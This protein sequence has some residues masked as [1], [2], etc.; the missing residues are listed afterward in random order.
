MRGTLLC[1]LTDGE[2][3]G[4]TLALGADLSDRLGLRLVLAHAV[5]V[6]ENGR[7]DGS[8]SFLARASRQDAERRL[9]RL[10]DEQGVADRAER[11]V[12]LGEPA[13]SIGQ[14]A[15]EE[16]ADVIVVG[17]RARGWRRRL[18]SRLADQLRTETPVPVLIAPPR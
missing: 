15:A 4:D 6:P 17:A 12:A 8:E 2:E 3:G 16:A 11:R 9:A 7:G 10:A 5:D 14:I 18:E 13:A 1:A